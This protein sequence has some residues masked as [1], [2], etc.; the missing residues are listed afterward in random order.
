MPRKSNHRNEYRCCIEMNQ[1]GK[2]CVRIR[3]QFHGANGCFPSIFWRRRSIAPSAS[4]SRRSNSCSG[5]RTAC[6][7][8]AW[9]AATTPTYPRRCCAKSGLRLDRRAEFPRRTERL[10]VAPGAAGAGVPAGADAARPGGIGRNRRASRIGREADGA[11][12]RA[13]DSAARRVSS[14][15]TMISPEPIN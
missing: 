15:R 7:S 4:W 5:T 11:P 10:V 1:N 6:G 12:A 2:Y 8:G 9:T 13:A 14:S 3:A